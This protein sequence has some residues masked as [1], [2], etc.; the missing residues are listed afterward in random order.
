MLSFEVK[1]FLSFMIRVF[2]FHQFVLF[3]RGKVFD[4]LGTARYYKKVWND[5]NIFNLLRNKK[6]KY[7]DPY[8]IDI[9]LVMLQY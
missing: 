4:V 3:N 8:L 6:A 5:K 9:F 1:Y 2:S 7:F